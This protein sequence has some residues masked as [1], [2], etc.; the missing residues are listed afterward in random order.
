MK[1]NSYVLEA[2]ILGGLIVMAA[3]CIDINVI[4]RVEG[5]KAITTNEDN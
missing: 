5:S 2:L 4:V 3:T 1:N